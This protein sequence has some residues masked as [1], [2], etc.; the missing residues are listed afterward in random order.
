MI[1][2]NAVLVLIIAFQVTK[3][4][5]EYRAMGPVKSTKKVKAAA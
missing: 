2:I 5:I 1:Y 3:L 4:T